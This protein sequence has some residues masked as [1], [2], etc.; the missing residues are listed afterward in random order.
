MCIF[1]SS[2]IYFFGQ[3]TRV[4]HFG[5]QVLSGSFLNMKEIE[6]RVVEAKQFSGVETTI[7]DERLSLWSTWLDMS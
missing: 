2:S 1:F 5:P 6:G 4:C 7:C 3:A